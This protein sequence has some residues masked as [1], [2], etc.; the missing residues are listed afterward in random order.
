MLDAAFL[1]KYAEYQRRY[2]QNI[3][4]SDKVLVD[5]VLN[6]L[7]EGARAST[8]RHLLDLGCSTGTL[9]L[10]LH[11]KRSIPGLAL[12]GGDMATVIPV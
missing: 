9:L 8:Q 5:L 11:L 4:E 1:E 7:D 12:T 6:I 10:H 2:A 3:R